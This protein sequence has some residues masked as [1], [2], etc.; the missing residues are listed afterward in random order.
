MLQRGDVAWSARHRL[1]A[2]GACVVVIGAA[3]GNKEKGRIT[4]SGP[5]ASAVAT[6][7]GSAPGTTGEPSA[8]SGGRS[9]ATIGSDT[10]ILPGL[11]G[12]GGSSAKTCR[13]AKSREVGVSDKAITIG[14]IVTDSNS[15]PQQLRP[16]HEGLQAFVNV[17]NKAGGLCG[18][19]LDLV[20]RNDNLNPATHSSDMQDLANR[21]LAFVGND[22]L[23]DF[24]DYDRNPPF[25]PT[26]RGNG[27]FVPDVGGLAFGYGR[28]QSNWHAGV[29][30]SV[31][32]VLVG[33]GQFKALTAEAKAKGTPCKKGGVVYL[34]EPTGASKD[35]ATL[36][37]AAVEASWGGGL[38]RGN[39]TMYEAELTDQD[40]NYQGLVTRMVNDGMNCVWAYTDLQ[41]SIRL[42]KAM[43]NGGYW[44]PSSCAVASRCFRVTWVPFT[45]YDDKFIRD[46]GAGAVGVAT[47][48]PHVPLSES[49]NGPVR[50]YLDAVKTVSGARPSTFSI[51]GFTSG[52]MLVQALQ[53]CPEAP[54][55]SCLMS[56]LRRMQDFAGGGLLG[57]TT[58]FKRTKATFSNFG[59]FDWKWIF[60]RSVALK[61]EKRGG[62][63]DF[64]RTNP[65]SGFLNDTLHVARGTAG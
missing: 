20:Y 12:G 45:V 62:K 61:V 13:P 32:P 59:T 26:V 40:V 60:F 10:P 36:G 16:V 65:G 19:K 64:F 44:P 51:F 23:L 27:S 52:L 35:Q 2:L 4:R 63:T 14:Q 47:F 43:H 56:A 21:V 7:T 29:V 1:V 15:L 58:P 3:C 34:N 38:G 33:G 25:D 18:R 41:G 55:R 42:V 11:T 50:A 37:A 22:S 54:T 9:S 31:S 28:A 48:I 53:S 39:T 5:S 6:P 24:L 49:T 30:G 17:F 46:G 57:G 8:G